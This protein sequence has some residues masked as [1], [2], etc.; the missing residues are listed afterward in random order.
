M[1]QKLN[2]GVFIMD[3]K[4]LMR[5]HKKKYKSGQ[6]IF[7]EGDKGDK[8]YIIQEGTIIIRKE[9]NGQKISV[10]TVSSGEILGEMA[11]LGDISNRSA[12]AMAKTDVSCLEFPEEKLDKLMEENSKFRNRIIRLLCKRINNTTEKHSDY[13][14]RN[15]LFYKAALFLFYQIDENDWYDSKNKKFHI[16]PDE[17]EAL[18][19]FDLSPGDLEEFL[20]ITSEKKF[21]R[22]EPD[23]K[24]KLINTMFKVLE[25][26]LENFTIEHHNQVQ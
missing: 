10:G 6:T 23:K 13:R 20:S 22:L 5:K 2:P 15:F 9:K 7:E 25:K 3:N 26:A 12:T 24:E 17:A 21:T 8:F 14:N 19:L 4:L 18:Q 1:K 11:L 16:T